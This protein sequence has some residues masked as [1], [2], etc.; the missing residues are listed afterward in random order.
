MNPASWKSLATAPSTVAAEILA[1]RLRAEGLEVDVR[2]D[3]ALL[4]EAR[5]CRLYVPENQLVRAQK[6]LA[7]E[8]IPESELEALA[9]SQDPP[10]E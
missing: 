3:T 9:T 2:T 4:G 1:G 10:K 5:L 8:A 7:E 6:I